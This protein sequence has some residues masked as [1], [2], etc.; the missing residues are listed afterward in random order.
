MFQR[1]G[2]QLSGAGIAAVVFV[3]LIV[4][5]LCGTQRLRLQPCF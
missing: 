2:K 5:G 3:V 1:L 4:A